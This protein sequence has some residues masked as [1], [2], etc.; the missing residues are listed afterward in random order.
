MYDVEEGNR[1]NITFEEEVKG[2]SS[3]SSLALPLLGIIKSIPVGASKSVLSLHGFIH[4]LEMFSLLQQ[5]NV[6]MKI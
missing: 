2:T 6:T 3:F 5:S 4:L 1:V